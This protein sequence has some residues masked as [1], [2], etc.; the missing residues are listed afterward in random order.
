MAAMATEDRQDGRRSEARGTAGDRLLE[1]AGRVFAA[2]GYQRASVDEI[3]RE[4]GLT[5]GALYWN[6]ES[7]QDLFF[8]LLAQR[9]DRGAQ[10]LMDA[11]TTASAEAESAPPVSAGMSAL[12]DAQREV[13]LL[14]HDY[15]SLAARDAELAQG[16][17]ER[18]RSLRQG[19]AR[20]L[21]ARHATTGVPLT[22]P[23]QRL[24]TVILALANGLAMDR[25]VDREA[26]PDELFGQALS[27]LYD[28][29]VRRAEVQDS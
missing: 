28:G 1:A 13:V 19:I 15:W 3:A 20:A 10:A 8:A 26:I 25:L 14:M 9:L 17:A 5:K 16:Y 21:E 24:A 23:A 11:A 4:A 27:L 29:L 12:I 6:F 18:Q 22:V 2:R 7:K